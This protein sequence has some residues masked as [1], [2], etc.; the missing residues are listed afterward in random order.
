MAKGG[1]TY[2]AFKA[3]ALKHPKANMLDATKRFPHIGNHQ[4]LGWMSR[5][6]AEMQIKRSK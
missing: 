6:S 2:I 4:L 5:F 3:W 1:S